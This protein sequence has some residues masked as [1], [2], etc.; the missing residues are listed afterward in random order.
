VAELL[1]CFQVNFV[2]K[3]IGVTNDVCRQ[4]EWQP[5]NTYIERRSCFK[6]D[7][8]SGILLFLGNDPSQIL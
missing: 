7:L 8:Q 1:S 5:T 3:V 6:K 2:S 4:D